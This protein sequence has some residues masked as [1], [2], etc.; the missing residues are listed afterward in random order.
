MNTFNTEM[1]FIISHTIDL[2]A[3]PALRNSLYST[4][5]EIKVLPPFYCDSNIIKQ[6]DFINLCENKMTKR[7]D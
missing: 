5:K 4:L 6:N 7:T 1:L 3:W 2:I